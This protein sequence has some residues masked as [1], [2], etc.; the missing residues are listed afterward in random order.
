MVKKNRHTFVED[1][2][3]RTVVQNEDFAQVGLNLSQVF[4]VDSVPEGTMLSVV[5]PDEP[6]P[7]HLQPFNDRVGI[8]LH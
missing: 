8:L 7:L 3:H 1:V 2:T 5:P 6:F 4:D